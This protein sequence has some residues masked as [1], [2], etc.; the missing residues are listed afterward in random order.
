MIELVDVGSEAWVSVEPGLPGRL[1]ESLQGLSDTAT[2]DVGAIRWVEAADRTAID[3]LARSVEDGPMGAPLVIACHASTSAREAGA[4]LVDAGW[5]IDAL[6]RSAS[7][8]LGLFRSPT[9]TAALLLG[10]DL[11][12]RILEPGRRRP[13]ELMDVTEILAMLEAHRGS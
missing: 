12:R 6:P 10:P 7:G 13:R 1:V 3:R 2:F 5:R 11:L 4:Q 9:G 8:I